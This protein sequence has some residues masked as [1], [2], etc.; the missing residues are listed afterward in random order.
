M[1]GRA[2]EDQMGVKRCGARGLLL[3]HVHEAE[4]NL[5]GGEAPTRSWKAGGRRIAQDSDEPSRASG[6]ALSADATNEQTQCL[7]CCSNETDF[8]EPIDWC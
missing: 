2:G 5:G 4:G 3:V 7:D 1:A 6:R 8:V